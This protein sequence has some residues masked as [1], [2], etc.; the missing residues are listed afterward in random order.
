MNFYYC[1]HCTNIL[2]SLN[3]TS[4]S[5]CGKKLKPL[6]PKK[7]EHHDL[8]VERVENDFYITAHH[9]MEHNHY[10]SFIALLSCDSM[11][12]KKLYPEWELQVRISMFAHG[13]L[14]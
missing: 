4:I 12:L 7:A 6:F 13:R 8:T 5:C 2:T 3:H 14:F 10:I 9:P 11:M 1:P